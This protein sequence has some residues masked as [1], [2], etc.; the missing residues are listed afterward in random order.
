MFPLNRIEDIK[1]HPEDFN[2]LERVPLTRNEVQELLPIKLVERLPNEQTFAVV[3]L[4]TET[5][6]MNPMTDKIIEL[7]MVRCTF[8]K[9]RKCLLSVDRIFDAYEDP[10][11]PIPDEITKLTGITNDMVCNQRFNEDVILS[12]VADGPL[13]VAHNARFDR[14]FVDRRFSS[15]QPLPWACSQKEVNWAQLGFNGFKLEFLVQSQGYFY[16]AHRACNDC[17]ALCHLMYLK[18]QAFAMLYDSSLC[19]AYR[20]EAH[21]APF[22]KKDTLKSAGYNWDP[23][24]KVWYFQAKDEEEAK[25][26]LSFLSKLY[27]EASTSVVVLEYTAFTRYRI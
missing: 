11:M 27:P 12:F 26:Q 21:K 13:M 10:K 15:W 17:L 24:E 20:I 25:K 9:D 2:L 7:G 14:P 8:S 19:K 6:G 23:K 18:P 16:D 5:T 1:Q 4:D 22:D 3:F